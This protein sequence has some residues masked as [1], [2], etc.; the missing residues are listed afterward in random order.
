MKEKRVKRYYPKAIR[1]VSYTIIKA[2]SA[3]VVPV[4]KCNELLKRE[5]GSK[6]TG[7]SNAR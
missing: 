7:R 6:L 2:A 4:G 3:V 1:G 5:A